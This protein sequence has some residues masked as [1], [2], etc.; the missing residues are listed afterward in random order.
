MLWGQRLD[1]AT[2]IVGITTF[3]FF[4]YLWKKTKIFPP[5]PRGF[6]LLGYIPF[7]KN[8]AAESLFKLKEK[9]G[10]VMSVQIGRENWIILNDYDAIIEALVKQGEKFSG[11]PRNFVFEL[12]TKHHGIIAMDYGHN[13]KALHKFGLMTLRGFGVGKKGMEENVIEETHFLIENLI[14][15][16]AYSLQKKLT[17]AASNIISRVVLGSRFEYDDK[18]LL[19]MT[20]IIQKF[21][22]DSTHARLLAV[23]TMAPILKFL[24]PFRKVVKI[25]SDDADLFHEYLY[26]IVEEHELNFD[27]YNIRDFIDAFLL[28]IKKSPKDDSVFNKRQLIQYIVDLFDAGSLTTSSTLSW[29]LL[30]LAHFQESQKKIAEEIFETLGEDGISSMKHRSEM[31]YTCA[32]IQELLRHRTL[33]PLSIFHKTNEEAII[34]GYSIPKNTTVHPNLWAV[35]FDPEYFENPEEFRPERFL[36][37]D[38]KFIKSNHVIPFSVGQRGCLGQQLAK[39]EIFII[40]TGIV[41]KLRVVP[42]P[43][44]PLPSF[45]IGGNCVATYEP[46]QYEVVFERR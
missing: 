31:P 22:E 32:F 43:E 12:I 19:H 1:Y 16:K 38:G 21:T 44:K 3:L 6:P 9:Y 8:N 17:L 7:L 14:T 33:V 2:Y 25:T 24:P 30:A 28:E 35:H 5:G 26:K 41:Q 11:R 4:Y 20:E 29:A 36:D 15:A 23:L 10:S 34:H 39:M 40:L 13:W 45:Y 37:G 42:D 46:P 27:Q 18:K